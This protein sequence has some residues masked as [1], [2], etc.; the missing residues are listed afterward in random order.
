MCLINFTLITFQIGSVQKTR[1]ALSMSATSALVDT[2]KD[3]IAYSEANP[4]TENPEES[5]LKSVT[6]NYDTRRYYVD[7]KQNSRGRFL[8]IAQTISFPKMSRSQVCVSPY[9][10]F[11]FFFCI[12]VYIFLVLG[13][14]PG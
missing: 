3:L 7:L 1:I 13:C 5:Q 9:R 4:V 2:I 10:V 14:L 8:R 11:T 6:L 12:Y